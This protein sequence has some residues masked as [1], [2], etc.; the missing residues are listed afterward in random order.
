MMNNAFRNIIDNFEAYLR[1]VVKDKYIPSKQLKE[2]IEYSLLGGGK[3]F[4]PL[5]VYLTGE[6]LQVEKAP[7]EIIAAA[8]EM[9]HCYSLIHDDLPAMDDDDYRRGKPSCHKAFDQ[10]TAILAGDALSSWSIELLITELPNYSSPDKILNVCQCLLHAI[11]VEGMISGQSLDLTVLALE[12]ANE[13]ELERIHQLKT[14]YLIQSCIMMVTELTDVSEQKWLALQ[15]FSKYLG[16]VFQMQDDYLDRYAP[17]QALG[18]MRSSDIANDKKTYAELYE[19]NPLK[20]KIDLLFASCHESLL[21]VTNGKSKLND[22][23][24]QLQSRVT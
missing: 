10:A 2:A 13:D 21:P 6:L 15:N 4:R 16:L 17:E 19:K 9:V 11:G 20:E 12:T 22:L 14:G 7:L 3:R 24:T 23:I 1:Q 18:K 8:V 5:L